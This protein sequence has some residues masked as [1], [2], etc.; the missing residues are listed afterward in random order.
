LDTLGL[1]SA[2]WPFFLNQQ[3]ANRTWAPYFPY[4]LSILS[5]SDRDHLWD[6]IRGTLLIFVFLELDALCKVAFDQGCKATFEPD[7]EDYP[8][9]IETP[10]GGKIGIS[11][12]ILTR[13]GM[14]FMSPQWIVR[15]SLEQPDTVISGDVEPADTVVRASVPPLRANSE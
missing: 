4:I 5:I 13:I 2:V 7:D 12:H 9:R 11:S 15:S 10:D 8:L 14:E 6:F 3:K 1:K